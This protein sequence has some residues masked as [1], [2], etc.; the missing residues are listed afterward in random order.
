MELID[1][2]SKVAKKVEKKTVIHLTADEK[3]LLA[4]IE[5][6]QAGECMRLEG[7]GGKCEEREK[8]RVWGWV[9]RERGDERTTRVGISSRCR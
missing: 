1:K 3:R 7:E 5:Q 9:L 2:L 6:Q 4:E 8:M